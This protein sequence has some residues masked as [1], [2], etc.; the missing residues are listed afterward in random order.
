MKEKEVKCLIWDLDNTLWSGVLSE[1]D[2]VS[3]K[4]EI[5][6]IIKELDARGILQSVASK[7]NYEDAWQKLKDFG[8]DHY[9]LYPQINWNAKSAFLEEIQKKLNI[10][11]DTIAFIDDQKFELDEVKSCFPEVECLDAKEYLSIL[12]YKRFNPRF[13]TEDASARR[14]MY[15]EDIQR[16][17]EEVAFIGPKNKF[18]QTLQLNFSI[19]SANENDL[20]RAEELTVRTNQLNATGITYSYEELDKFRLSPIHELLVCELN[21]KYGTYG[22]IG[23]VLIEKQDNIWIIRLLLMSCRVISRGVGTVLLGYVMREVLRNG[24]KLRADF[25]ATDRNRA[26]YIAYKFA[27][28]Y[29]IENDGNGNIVFQNDLLF[30]PELPEYI[31]LQVK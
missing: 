20:K 6:N 31:K 13:I 9:F 24:V 23:L 16:Q 28:F 2:E 11:M 14:K 30:I 1:N 3:L 22:K 27:G 12:S 25:K 8:I 17:S 4:P 10:G 29:E 5:I 15:Q 19:S 18:L 7:N 21:D 26:M